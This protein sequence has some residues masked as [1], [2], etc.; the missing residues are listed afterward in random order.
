[1]RGAGDSRNG[2]QPPAHGERGQSPRAR[3]DP[4]H[5]PAS[6][7]TSLRPDSATRT[8]A[9]TLRVY[10]HMIRSAE[11]TAADSFAGAVKAAC[12]QTRKQ[13]PLPRLEEASE[14][15]AAYRNRTDDLRITRGLL[16][17][18]ARASCTDSIH[19]RTDRTRRAGIDRHAVPRPK[20]LILLVHNLRSRRLLTR[21][22]GGRPL[23]GVRVIVDI[24]PPDSAGS[25]PQ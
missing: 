1:M 20:P 16:P 4:A 18:R 10:A 22:P 5:S 14:L 23:G 7:S 2:E 15:G 3:T 21:R 24:Y 12:W 13:K 17:A 11:T 19:S 9:I 6:R 25:D 8:P